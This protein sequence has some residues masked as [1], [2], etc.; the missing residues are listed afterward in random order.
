M[1]S[2]LAQLFSDPRKKREPFFGKTI[3]V[4]QPPKQ[5]GKKG[6]TEQLSWCGRSHLLSW[7]IVTRGGVFPHPPIHKQGLVKMGSAFEDPR[8][9]CSGPKGK[10]L[11]VEWQTLDQGKSKDPTQ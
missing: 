2:H 9:A 10:G 11:R 5:K 3:L 1:R 8:P 6:A 4:G 7:G